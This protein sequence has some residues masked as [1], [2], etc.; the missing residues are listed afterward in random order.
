S[1][2]AETQKRADELVK[3]ISKRVETARLLAA[4]KLQLKFKDTPVKEALE[5]LSKKSEY[6]VVAHDP[7]NKLNDR[8]V[9]LETEEISFWEAFD[10][11]CKA[12]NL[13]DANPQDLV[14]Q[15]VPVPPDGG[16]VPVPPGRLRPQVETL[17][18][19]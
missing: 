1:D 3:N 11:L 17:P 5:Q 16:P 13:V 9:T 10:K 19:E 2:D 18:I 15:P 12:A 4:T 7:N 8:K 14:G 6:Q